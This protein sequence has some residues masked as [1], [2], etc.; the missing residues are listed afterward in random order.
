MRF[1][2]TALFLLLLG[3]AYALHAQKGK[4]TSPLTVSL[5]ASRG[6]CRWTSEA[7]PSN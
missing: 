4:E 1:A 7:S 5:Q 2:K 3:S 6:R